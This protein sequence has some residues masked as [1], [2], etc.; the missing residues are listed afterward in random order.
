MFNPELL[1]SRDDGHQVPRPVPGLIR[2]GYKHS[3]LSAAL[4]GFILSAPCVSG[5]S[6]NPSAG[7]A[8]ENSKP[9][10]CDGLKHSDSQRLSLATS[11]PRSLSAGD[12]NAEEQASP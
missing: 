1:L 6:G 3:L 12:S 11:G 5:Q 7:G 9:E 4:V 2:I 10:I 8:Q